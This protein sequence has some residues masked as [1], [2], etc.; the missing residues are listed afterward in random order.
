MAGLAIGL[1]CEMING[2]RRV[3]WSSALL[4]CALLLTGWGV[5]RRPPLP[6]DVRFVLREDL[7]L[8]SWIKANVPED[9]R[10][11]GR[12]G[13]YHRI[14]Q[15]RDAAMWAPYFTRHLTNHT[16]LAASLEKAPSPPREK[17]VVFTS[18]LYTRDMSAPESARWMQDQGYRWF[19]SGAN[20]PEILPVGSPFHNE[21]DLKLSRQ[22]ARNPAF[23]LVC[24]NGAARL[25]RVK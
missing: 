21:A 12:G 18:E 6:E 5:H 14:V 10:I 20:A 23:E 22:L 16:L 2:D 9:E 7:P 17:A 15:G 19:Y 4:F 1:F 11:A 3:V 13:F 25:Y 24:R 8:M